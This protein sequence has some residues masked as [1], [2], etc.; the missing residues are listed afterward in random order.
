MY[1]ICT[2]VFHFI[3]NSVIFRR[4]VFFI[5]TYYFTNEDDKAVLLGIIFVFSDIDECRHSNG[6]CE[7][8]CSNVVGSY[9][10]SCNSGYVLGYDKARCIGKG[11]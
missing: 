10:C 11:N 3:D 8:I 2:Y 4:K 7:H 6:G 5:I 1:F 9:K